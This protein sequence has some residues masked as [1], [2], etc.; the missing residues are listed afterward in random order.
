[1]ESGWI[2]VLVSEFLNSYRSID[3]SIHRPSDWLIRNHSPTPSPC[4]VILSLALSLPSA[5]STKWRQC[6]CSPHRRRPPATQATYLPDGRSVARKQTEIV[7]GQLRGGRVLDCDVCPAVY[8]FDQLGS[9]VER[10]VVV[11]V[12]SHVR[13]HNHD[14][15]IHRMDELNGRFSSLLWTHGINLA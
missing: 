15:Q 11:G 12:I 14:L 13:H 1:M 2:K 9:H 4:P 10:E 3:R 6:R 7:V 5:T 8:E